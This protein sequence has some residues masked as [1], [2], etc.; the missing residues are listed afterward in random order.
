MSKYRL[1]AKVDINQGDIVKELRKFPGMT[2][3]TGHDDILCGL[4]GRTFWYEI[5]SE[6][7]VSKKDGKVLTSKKKNS[8]IIL[9]QNW[10]GHYKIVSSLEEILTDININLKTEK[11]VK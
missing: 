2:V 4:K 6:K 8:Q 10:T 9:E 11:W 1:A 3:E 7:A 5:K